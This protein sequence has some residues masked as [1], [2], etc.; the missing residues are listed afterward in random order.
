M[1]LGEVISDLPSTDLEITEVKE[2]Y[3]CMF[4]GTKSRS[5]FCLFYYISGFI[6]SCHLFFIRRNILD[7]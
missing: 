1:D 5:A 7:T 4:T 3:V 2:I 6:F